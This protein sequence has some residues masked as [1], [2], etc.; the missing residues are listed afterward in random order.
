MRLDLPTELREP[1]VVF[2]P[3]TGENPHVISQT[4]FA[5]RRRRKWEN[6]RCRV[7]QRR[8]DVASDLPEPSQAESRDS[9][10]PVARV[11]L[12]GKSDSFILWPSMIHFGVVGQFQP[13][14]R[15]STIR[16]SNF[17]RRTLVEQCDLLG[18][19]YLEYLDPSHQLISFYA[20]LL[21]AAALN[22][23]EENIHGHREIVQLNSSA[24]RSGFESQ[25]IPLGPSS[26][27][28]FDDDG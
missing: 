4:S 2:S 16:R 1:H 18:C 24:K 6:P 23:V 28:P 27:A 21:H 17:Q 12:V 15:P 22:P 9:K 10:R 11:L 25:C 20:W 13:E 3:I 14:A 7:R 26:S 8:A 5:R 19:G